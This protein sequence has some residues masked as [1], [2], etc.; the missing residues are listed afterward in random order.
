MAGV[1]RPAGD[2]PIYRLRINAQQ[3]RDVDF[4]YSDG[5]ESV[6]KEM[7]HVAPIGD[8][9]SMVANSSGDVPT[10]WFSGGY[11]ASTLQT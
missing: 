8:G 9:E 5:A 1:W 6:G 11:G 3:A 4:A 2:P 7:V 10:A